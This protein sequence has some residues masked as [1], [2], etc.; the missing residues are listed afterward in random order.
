MLKAVIFDI[1]GVLLDSFEAN[2]QHARDMAELAGLKAPTEKQYRK[3][4]HLPFR[5]V[6]ANI[7]RIKTLYQVEQALVKARIEIDYPVHLLKYYD[8]CN[9][10]LA[11]LSKKYKLGVVSSRTRRGIKTY[12]EYSKNKKLFKATI[13]VEDVTNH[14]PHPEP[15]LL[16]AKKLRVKPF[17]AAYVGDARSD[18]QAANA[19]GMLAIAYNQ[20][21]IPGAT[22]TIRHF[23]ELIPLLRTLGHAPKLPKPK[24]LK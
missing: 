21:P 5:H 2:L 13:S 16:A 15:L 12:L 20:K 23:K 19:A 7:N 18:V 17:E 10:T 1:D 3:M 24:N 11:Q 14:K 8:G 4:F 6:F 9:R 22:A